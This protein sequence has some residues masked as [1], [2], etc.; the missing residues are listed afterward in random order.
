MTTVSTQPKLTF[1]STWLGLNI[2]KKKCVNQLSLLY[3]F[4]HPFTLKFTNPASILKSDLV[5]EGDVPEPTKISVLSKEESLNT[6]SL[7]H[8]QK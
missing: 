4:L 8:L 6:P 1:Y 3:N 5:R 7:E 2:H